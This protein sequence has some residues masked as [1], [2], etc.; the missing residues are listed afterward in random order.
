MSWIKKLK[1]HPCFLQ[2]GSDDFSFDYSVYYINNKRGSYEPPDGIISNS[3][4][5]EIHISA[6][7]DSQVKSKESIESFYRTLK[8]D[9]YRDQYLS[10]TQ[11]FARWLSEQCSFKECVGVYETCDDAFEKF[12]INISEQTTEKKGKEHTIRG[13]ETALKKCFHSCNLEVSE[14][15][16]D[17]IRNRRKEHK[18]KFPSVPR[19]TMPFNMLCELVMRQFE[20][21]YT[22]VRGGVVHVD[23]RT[24]SGNKKSQ[25]S[26]GEVVRDTLNMVLIVLAINRPSDNVVFV[27]AVERDEDQKCYTIRRGG[28]FGRTE[29]G[30]EE[31][32]VGQRK[33]D[34]G[35]EDDE[36]R[37]YEAEDCYVDPA[38]VF[39]E[40]MK[41]IKKFKNTGG[42]GRI[43][44]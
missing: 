11:I 18:D 41:I 38:L 17:V 1:N 25:L 19:Y 43:N 7:D 20:A 24:Q 12:L 30:D 28:A 29:S 15:S 36:I 8:K 40:G 34:G 23:R 4:F 39:E 33:G 6:V 31:Y 21:F 27:D 10:K 2:W 26:K 42:K 32:Q 44:C 9:R 13:F 37:I 5:R 22:V 16:L 3:M 35:K 14:Y